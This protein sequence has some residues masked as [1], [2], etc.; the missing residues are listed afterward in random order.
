MSVIEKRK[1]TMS[2]SFVAAPG[3]IGIHEAVDYVP[4][5]ILDAYV[6]DAQQRWQNVTVGDAHDPGPG[7]DAGETNIPPHLIKEGE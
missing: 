5:D 7:G 6:A 2:S 4:L 1:V 3:Q